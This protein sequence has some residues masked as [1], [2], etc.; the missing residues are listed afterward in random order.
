MNEL[1]PNFTLHETSLAD[2]MRII[3]ADQNLVAAK[4]SQ[5]L[6][7]LR[8]IADWIERPLELIPAV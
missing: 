3:K 4:K 1:S 7:S 8:R 6:C 5:W 2:A